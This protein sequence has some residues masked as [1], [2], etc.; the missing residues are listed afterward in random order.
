MAR[1]IDKVKVDDPAGESWHGEAS[2]RW[3]SA[4]DLGDVLGV[5]AVE[6]YEPVPLP[7]FQAQASP[8]VSR[9]VLG[10]FVQDRGTG[11]V[12]DVQA[13]VPECGV[14]AIHNA[15]FFHFWSEVVAAAGEDTPCDL[16]IP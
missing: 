10:R 16:C 5:P 13:A 4:V 7:D 1:K 12:H 9:E 11:I 15:T 3:A 6:M 2:R 8:A 14:D